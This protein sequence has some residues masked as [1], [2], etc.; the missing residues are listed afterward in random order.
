MVSVDEYSYNYDDLVK[1]HK[2][3]Q[4]CQNKF[5]NSLGVNRCRKCFHK[6]TITKT[7]AKRIYHITDADIKKMHTF[8]IHTMHKTMCTLLLL[9][10]VRMKMIKREYNVT[11]VNEE[12]YTSYIEMYLDEQD[13]KMEEKE[14]KRK[15]KHKSR[16]Q[17]LKH[18]LSKRN[19]EYRSDSYYCNQY[20]NGKGTLKE[21]CDMM[22]LMKF[23]FEK[24]N[25]QD[26]IKKI[27]NENK[28]I[29][30]YGE[31]I[32][33]LSEDDKEIAK[34]KALKKYSKKNGGLPEN[35]SKIYETLIQ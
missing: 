5:T 3:C 15:E 18:A 12:D 19:L 34:C 9:K 28:E 22:E 10:E 8:E 2:H 14:T 4:D 29:R 31:Y 32:Q 11:N 24:T 7:E 23:L 1:P 16:K 20:I 30:K 26:Q 35:I 25:Y 6:Y 17:K 13:A 21:V 33:I 27:V